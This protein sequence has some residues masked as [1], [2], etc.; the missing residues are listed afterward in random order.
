[1]KPAFFKGLLAV[2]LIAAAVPVAFAQTTGRIEGVVLDDQGAGLPGVTVTISSASLQGDRV[3][4]T[5][6]DG[7]FRFL[8]LPPGDYTLRTALEGYTPLEQ[9]GISVQLDRTVSLQLTMASGFGDEVTVSGAAPIIDTTST[10]TGANFG[11]ELFQELPV[12]RTFQ[13][14]AFAAPGVVSGGLGDNPSI[15]GAS[16]AENRYVVDGLDTTDAAFGTIATEVPFEFI[17]EVEVKTGGYEAEYGGALGGVLNVITKSGGND[18]QGDL[19]GYWSDDSLQAEAEPIVQFGQDLGFEEYDFG[20]ALGGKFIQDKLWYFVAVNPSRKD[21]NY[22]TRTDVENEERTDTLFYAGKLTW[23]LSPSHQLVFSA[24]G[25]PTDIEQNLTQRGSAGLVGDDREQGADNFGATYNGTLSSNLFVEVSAGRSDQTFRQTPFRT[26]VG[27]YELRTLGSVDFALRE[28]CPG[29]NERL[30]DVDGSGRFAT[31]FFNPGCLGGTFHQE[32]GD[33]KRDEIR[34]GLTW[35]TQTGAV[36]HEIKAGFSHREVEYIDHSH[37]PGPVPGPFFDS[38][39]GSVDANG[40]FQPG[41]PVEPDG[42]A[43]QRWLLFGGPDEGGSAILI[44]YD[45]NSLGDTEEQALFL[46]DRLRLGDYFSLNLGVRADQYNSKGDLSDSVAQREL[47]FSFDDQ[48]APRVGFT[49]DVARNGRSKLYGHYGQFYESVPLD[50]NARAFGNERFNFFYFYYPEDGSL[51]TPSNPGTHYYT[52]RLGGG[53]RVD[54]DIE[55][56]YTEEYLVGFEYE[57]LPN[58]A[59]GVKYTDRSIENVIEDISVDGGQHYFI[60]NPGGTTT[61]EPVTGTPLPEP[62]TFPE[63]VRD[64]SGF[65]VSLNKRFT[66]NWQ[67]YASYVNSENEGNY[68]GLFRQDNGQ[69]DPNITSLFD[70][71]ELLEGA[72]GRLPN[73]REHQVKVYGSYLWPFKLITGFYA[74]YLS[75]T[76]ITQLGAHPTYGR[77]ERF[78][79]QRGSFGTNPDTYNIDLHLEYPITF[80]G[81]TELKLI[82]DVFNITDEQEPTVVDEEWTRAHVRTPSVLN[83]DGTVNLEQLN[84]GG[85]GTGPGTS[86]PNGNPLFGEPTDRQDPRTIRLGVKLSF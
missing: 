57:V 9:T 35:F 42:L 45:Q 72:F 23:Q 49:W 68:G 20:A 44:E 5:G 81:G 52:Y 1:M 84:C 59:V 3:Q 79:S 77:R 34:P 71:P 21:E 61:V 55:P 85:P 13:G 60:T 25:D 28:N 76:P 43:G 56:M 18:L 11:E 12:T 8:A 51:P 36:D 29:D 73:D 65:E 19:F 39:G 22:T 10:T 53:T 32:N 70:L 67:L 4:V 33:T 74:Q 48:L 26:D 14:L 82:A 62:V 69:L 47:D 41:V 7:R 64:Y 58:V 80:G 75:G 37:Y 24:F 63:A 6:A 86:C 46:Q 38:N 54:P 15:A 78:V 2:A 27:F 16:A 40:V 31:G 17:R 66:N 83:P 50:I 30:R